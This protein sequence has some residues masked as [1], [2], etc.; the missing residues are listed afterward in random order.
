M[1]KIMGKKYLQFYDEFF[2][3]LNLCYQLALSDLDLHGL[4]KV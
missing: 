2:V 1:L 4:Q 3:Y